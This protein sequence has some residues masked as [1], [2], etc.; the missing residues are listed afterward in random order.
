MNLLKETGDF[1]KNK[2]ETQTKLLQVSLQQS[3][4]SLSILPFLKS[5]SIINKNS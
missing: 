2:R 4:D 1:S 5:I 3:W